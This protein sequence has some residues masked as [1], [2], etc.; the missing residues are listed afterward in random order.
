MATDEER[1]VAEA[2][3]DP[4]SDEE[5]MLAFRDGDAAA[6]EHLARRHQRP[7]YNFLLRSVHN[8][9]RAEEL[10]QE[11]FLRVVRAKERYQQTARFT[12]WL[13]T[14]ARNLCVD[15]SRRQR[16]RRTASLEQKRGADGGGTSILD[17]TAADDPGVDAQ[18]AGPRIQERMQRA[19]S[20]LPEEQREVFLMRQLSGMSFKQIG[21]AVGAPEN[22]VKSRMRYALEKLRLEL[23]DLDPRVPAASEERPVK[24]EGSN[25]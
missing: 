13:Y 3:N 6:F 18:A 4:R 16:F 8:K 10:L 15:E 21:E 14:I 12:T 9:A 25:G 11:V 24:K 5:L 1:A 20:E 7:V 22:T 2:R 23:A 19:I 17:V